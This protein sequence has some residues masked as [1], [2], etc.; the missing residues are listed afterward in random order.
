[1]LISNA[2]SEVFDGKLDHARS[3]DEPVPSQVK[4]A[5]NDFPKL[6]VNSNAPVGEDFESTPPPPAD[7]APAPVRT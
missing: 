4:G 5:V 2:S 3:G 7:G 1:M 6:L